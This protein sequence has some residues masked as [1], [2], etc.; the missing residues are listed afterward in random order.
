MN[1]NPQPPTPNPQSSNPPTP[2]PHPPPRTGFAGVGRV[3]RALLR[4]A[5]QVPALV[6]VAVQDTVADSLAAAA[7]AAPGLATYTDFE[8]MLET[9]GLDAVVISTLTAFHMPYA[10]MALAR[11]LHVLLQPPLARTLPDA[12][13]LLDLAAVSAGRLVLDTPWRYAPATAAARAVVAA[14]RLG[15]L[16]SAQARFHN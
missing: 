1:T 15:T 3:G 6:P 8:A 7:Q 2:T 10:R 13:T 9:A 4:A 14:G 12:D 11:G 16:L 5:V